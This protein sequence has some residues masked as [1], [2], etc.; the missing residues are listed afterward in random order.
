MAKTVILTRPHGPYAGDEGLWH[1]LEAV[2]FSVIRL[3]SLSVEAKELTQADAEAIGSSV[4]SAAWWVAF[5][6]PTAVHVFRDQ[7]ARLGIDVRGSQARLAAQGPGTSEAVRT[8]FHREVD[9]ESP[10][11]L[12]EVFAEQLVY[13]LGT[14]GRVL[15][16]Q[17]SEG[18]DVFAPVVRRSGAEVLSIATYGLVT[19]TPRDEDI[20]AVRGVSPEDSFLVF[21]SPSAVASTVETFP[22]PEHLKTL[23]VVSIG[24]VTSKA[25][26]D[27]GLKVFAEAKEHTETGVVECLM[28]G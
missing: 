7:C 14:S 4:S 2:G 21:M 18:R 20:A 8:I 26:R 23:R 17:S 1:R 3:S 10:I 28:E 27:A 6:S 25:V 5:L 11:A 22:D 19:T 24:P 15:V 16:P 12:A 13:R 9:L